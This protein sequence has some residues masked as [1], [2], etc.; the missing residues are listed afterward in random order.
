MCVATRSFL[1]LAQITSK[2]WGWRVPL[3]VIEHP[4][5][6]LKREEL[7]SRAHQVVESFVQLAEAS[8]SPA[9]SEQ[10]HTASQ[11]LFSVDR[12]P[13]GFLD[14]IQAKGWGDGLPVLHPTP[15]RV[16]SMLDRNGV[17][18]D[19]PVGQLPPQDLSVVARDVATNAVMTGLPDE[20]FPVVLAAI[21]A[22]LHQEFNLLGVLATTH[23]CGVAV[24]VSGP[25]ADAL[26]M[27]SGAGLYGPGNRMNAAIG[28]ALRLSLQNLGGAWPVLVDKSTQGHP[29]KY[30]YCFA[31]SR[32]AN[33]WTPYHVE[34]G[35]SESDST[36]TVI[37][38][39]GPHSIHDPASTKAENLIQYIIGS[40][41]HTG[42]NHFYHKGDLFLVLSPEHVRLLASSGWTRDM[43][44]NEIHTRARVRGSA[45]GR[46]AYDY[47]TSRWPTDEAR[48]D[49]YETSELA[50]TRYPNQI[51]IVVAGGP[52]KHSSWLPSFGLNYSS[53]E[54]VEM[55]K[56]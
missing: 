6:G 18:G 1:S 41:T 19:S 30:S 28:R 43:I 44:R 33:P 34:R 48:P 51:R 2:A 16:A 47:F 20:A 8:D 46:E 52:G 49:A 32:A 29:A 12:D 26:E 21:K 38:A 9:A 5:G 39:E 23:A 14:F 54:P 45:L 15:R 55:P 35:F 17:D 11:E 3:A 53:I 36:V 13:A 31:E 56:A 27:N 40:M 42:H 4:L 22:S 7:G 25:L 50:I 24:L 10:R 37:A